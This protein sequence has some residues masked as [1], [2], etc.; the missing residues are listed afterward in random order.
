MTNRSFHDME[1]VIGGNRGIAYTL[2]PDA[3]LSEGEIIEL[4][5]GDTSV[6]L[7]RTGPYRLDS[8]RYLQPKDSV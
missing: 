5:P 1:A 3:L 2:G 8:I 6:A 4:R 7:E